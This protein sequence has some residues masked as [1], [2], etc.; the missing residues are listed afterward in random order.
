MDDSAIR[1]IDPDP[2]RRCRDCPGLGD[3]A[4]GISHDCPTV[5]QPWDM[6]SETFR[7]RKS[8]ERLAKLARRLKPIILDMIAPEM[9]EIAAEVVQAA[10]ARK[11]SANG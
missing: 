1:L 8:R 10:L 3:I 6:P 4:C 9:G 11:R 5:R 2:T 7:A